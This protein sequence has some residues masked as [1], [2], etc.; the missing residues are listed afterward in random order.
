M[1]DFSCKTDNSLTRTT[2]PS[3][4]GEENWKGNRRSWS[5]LYLVAGC[6]H[7]HRH[8]AGAQQQT[9]QQ[10]EVEKITTEVV[11]ILPSTP[12][13]VSRTS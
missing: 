4:A 8:A 7:P 12:V 11:S 3:G 6:I 10:Q 2:K 13:A 9:R 5:F 1:N